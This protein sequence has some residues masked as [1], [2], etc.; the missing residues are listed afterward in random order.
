MASSDAGRVIAGSARGTRLA[1][2][3]AGTR[4]LGDRVKQ[5]LFAI[6]EPNLAGSAV[7][8]CCAGS[9]AAGIEALSR[10]AR[11]AVFVERDAGACRTIA[12][13]LTRTGL[14]D[15]AVV[16]RA[17]A[18]AYLAGRAAGDGPFDVVVVDPPYAESDLRGR[19]LDALGLAGAPLRPGGSLV[20]SG[21]WRDPP[22]AAAG[23]LRSERERRVGETLLTFYRR[24]AADAPADGPAE[25]DG[26]PA[27]GTEG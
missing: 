27:A 9:G 11:R 10:G 18:L 14:V 4:P 7:L 6:L 25:R 24:V 13:N 1:A 3:G 21:P 20:I 5:V 19:L 15:R 8:D 16:V 23:L 2:P 17:D 12:A 22:L 26:Q